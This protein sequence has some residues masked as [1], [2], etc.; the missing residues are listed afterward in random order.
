[1]ATTQATWVKKLRN[2]NETWGESIWLLS[3]FGIISRC[4]QLPHRSHLIGHTSPSPKSIFDDFQG[5]F[6][7]PSPFRKSTLFFWAQQILLL[8]QKLL[9]HIFW[10]IILSY[11]IHEDE[12]GQQL[13]L[14]ASLI[15]RAFAWAVCPRS[16]ALAPSGPALAFLPFFSKTAS[17]SAHMSLPQRSQSWPLRLD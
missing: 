11:K 10:F 17:L 12:R 15:R 13:P 16:P 1:M 6:L 14:K 5:H 9:F 8:S 2:S 7:F 4:Y 3:P